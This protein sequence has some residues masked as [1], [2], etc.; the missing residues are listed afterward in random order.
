L[1]NGIQ[2]NLFMPA[3]PNYFTVRTKERT[4]Q[5]LSRILRCMESQTHKIL[6]HT[7]ASSEDI[8][9]IRLLIKRLRALL[10]FASPA[11]RKANVDIKKSK[12]NLRRAA[13]LLSIYR[14]LS[15]TQKIFDDL[16]SRHSDFPAPHSLLQAAGFR[17]DYHGDARAKRA[18]K[19]SITILLAEIDSTRQQCGSALPWPSMSHRLHQ[20]FR[21]ARKAGAKALRGHG[22][23]DFH[24][25]RKKTKNLLYQIQLSGA[26]H[27]RLRQ[28][29]KL[30]EGLGEYHDVIVAKRLLR[31]GPLDSRHHDAV[32]RQRHLLAEKRRNLRK[33]LRKLARSTHLC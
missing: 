25:W 8:H 30:Q 29:K 14:D 23:A 16:S 31:K 4:S 13:Q 2:L 24:D 1:L 19:L 9:R 20:A 32:K 26:G 15:A 22:S 11:L 33:R 27:K 6:E 10:W 7:Q 18:L 28:V 17:T 3:A 21:R 5:A 12:R